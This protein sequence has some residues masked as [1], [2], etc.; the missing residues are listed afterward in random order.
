M[1]I[2]YFYCFWFSCYLRF[3]TWAIRQ[4]F[5]CAVQHFITSFAYQLFWFFPQEIAKRFISCGKPVLFIQDKHR[6]RNS[7]ECLLPLF[8]GSSNLLFCFPAFSHVSKEAYQIV[9]SA[10]SYGFR[11]N[12]AKDYSFIFSQNRN[13]LRKSCFPLHLLCELVNY[14]RQILLRVNVAYTHSE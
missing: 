7:I 12:V 9:L 6:I 5:I 4:G 13:V 11:V 14:I 1:S 10:N 8:S 3:Y 2:D